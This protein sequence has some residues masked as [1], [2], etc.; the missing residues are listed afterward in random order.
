MKITDFRVCTVG[1]GTGVPRVKRRSPATLVKINRHLLLFDTGPGTLRALEEAG[2][3]FRDIDYIFYT[4]F[5]PDHLSDLVPF[6][7]VAHSPD[8]GRKKPVEI[9]GAR[10]LAKIYH[11][12]VEIFGHWV[13][14]SPSELSIKEI[15]SRQINNF[16]VPFG[17]LITYPMYHTSR[18]VGYRIEIDDVPYLAITGDTEYGE[19]VLKLARNV[20]ILVA[21]CSFPD[22]KEPRGH[23]TPSRVG[24]IAR[25]AN[26]KHLVL[27]H[28]YPEC[29][30]VNLFEQVRK[31]FD[32]RI[33]VGR[34]LMWIV[35]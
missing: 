16:E 4:H 23:L 21:E 14:L 8:Y 11:K 27:T 20:K 7:F 17:K 34:D 5:H 9:W 28:M 10:G 1:T 30:K 25:E 22:P 31:E 15:D 3:S 29:D 18:S 2:R 13:E 24:R 26:C 12:Y 35:F 6:L 32:G 33:T 19:N